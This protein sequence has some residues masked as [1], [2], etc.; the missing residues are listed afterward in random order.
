[1]VP[2]KSLEKFLAL[3][4][5]GG[6]PFWLL[7]VGGDVVFSLESMTH[8]HLFGRPFLPASIEQPNPLGANTSTHPKPLKI[9]AN[10]TQ[11]LLQWLLKPPPTSNPSMDQTDNSNINSN[12][13]TSP[14]KKTQ[15]NRRFSSGNSSEPDSGEETVHG[16]S[17]LMERLQEVADGRPATRGGGGVNRKEEP[18]LEDSRRKFLMAMHPFNGKVVQWT[19]DDFAF[20]ANQA[21]DDMALETILHRL[22]A[23]G[24][25]PSYDMER[26][27]VQTRW[28]EWQSTAR[29]CFTP[30]DSAESCSLDMITESVRKILDQCQ[31]GSAASPIAA[32][33]AVNGKK[34]SSLQ[35]AWGGIGGFDG[36][37]ALGHGIMYC[38]DKSWWNAWVAYS[39][40][41]YESD[42][43]RR[44][45]LI[46]PGQLSSERLLD[47][48]PESGAA[49]TLGSYE[50][51]KQDLKRD[52]DYVLVPQGVWDVLYELY[53]GGPPLPRPVVVPD[54]NGS[55]VENNTFEVTYR[56]GSDDDVG[57][58]QP[59]DER[60]GKAVGMDRVFRIPRALRVS[61]HPWILH[62][63]LCDP[64]QPYRRGDIGPMT[65]R[66]MAC[67]DQPLWRLFAEAIVRLPLRNMKVYGADGRGRARLWKKITP[68]GPKDPLSRY[69]PWT[70]LCKNRHAIL[71]MTNYNSELS[72]NYEELRENWESYADLASVEGV[73]LTDGDHL[74]LEC[75]TPN[76]NGDF[77]WPR[78]AAAK[79]GR[80]R[81][82]ADEDMKFRQL[83]RG[84]DENGDELDDP[85]ELV[86]MTVDAMDSAG[87]WYQVEILK[88]EVIVVEAENGEENG[89]GDGEQGE[90]K[91]V[92]VDFTEFGG[93]FE[94]IDTESDR[95]ANAG[96]FTMTRA[97]ESP[98]AQG[99]ATNGNNSTATES[100]SKAV[101]SAKKGS[102]E[103]FESNGKICLFPGYGACGLVNLGNTCYINSAIQC[104]SYMPLLRSYLLSA[105]YKATGDLNRDNPLGTGGKLLEEFAE[106]LRVMWS[107]RHGEKSPTRFR[108]QLGKARSQFSG[109]DQQDAQEFLNY[110]LDVL[111]EDS[112]KIRKKPYVEALEDDWVK[113]TNLPRV[114]AEA[115]RRYVNRWQKSFSGKW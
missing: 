10:G 66:V 28:I 22:F 77:A 31:N 78:E 32:G 82:L 41:S 83:L 39:G 27:I 6:V 8:Y 23:T 4:P 33:A 36:R 62:V 103:S 96:R 43:G 91:Q 5:A 58:D 1:M 64:L 3:H 35:R 67:P 107:A 17:E 60:K 11:D 44:S 55:S 38:I 48:D 110:I 47:R 109:A 86:G 113:V 102:S 25:L 100:K 74:M 108:T 12:K 87:R 30:G 20:W 14:N 105:Q 75:A 71:P 114:G 59:F 106:L 61:L 51:M 40:W 111:H 37:G 112:N 49:G 97:E 45:S 18:G 9:S 99:R 7:E 104:I 93:H 54:L 81:R 89:S 84:V 46:R 85:P 56:G 42:L 95:L 98:T 72:E 73:A 70:L 15:Q 76:K 101:V 68:G 26:D 115:W 65:I 80:V 69:G 92:K 50:L 34:G 19:I 63:H 57:A 88:V 90:S 79:A 52:V 16:K 29:H 2:P 21:L 13:I 53:G 94:W 24:I